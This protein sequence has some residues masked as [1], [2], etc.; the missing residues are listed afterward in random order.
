MKPFDF[1]R[2]RHPVQGNL[3]HHNH[4]L[5]GYGVPAG[6]CVEAERPSWFRPFFPFSQFRRMPSKR[7]TSKVPTTSRWKPILKE[8]GFTRQTC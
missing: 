2:R 6:I 8:T 5:E 1:Q 7:S 3:D 4:P